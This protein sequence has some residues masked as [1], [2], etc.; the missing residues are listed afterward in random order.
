MEGKM[1]RKE[2]RILVTIISLVVVP[3]VYS[4]YIYKKYLANTPELLNDFTFWGKTFIKMVPVMIVAIILI[5]IIFAII[6]KIITN[7][8]MPAR[9]DE[10][11][12]LIELKTLRISSWLY[13][14]GFVLA[15]GSQ[16][17]GMQPWVLFI[18]LIASCITGSVASGIAQIYYYRK[19]I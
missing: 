13:S 6:N 8:D 4:L 2:K 9:A 10:M 14:L 15:M 5:H 16:A 12:K 11:D 17:I 1:Y 19:G 7:E 18:T 3:A